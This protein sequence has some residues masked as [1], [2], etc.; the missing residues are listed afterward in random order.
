MCIR[1]SSLTCRA[2]ALARDA[3]PRTASVWMKWWHPTLTHCLDSARVEAAL[4]AKWP[5]RAWL[6]PPPYGPAERDSRMARRR[7]RQQPIASPKSCLR[8][9]IETLHVILDH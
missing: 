2:S 7:V 1:D 6:G 8:A 3:W 5:K 4:R 9:L